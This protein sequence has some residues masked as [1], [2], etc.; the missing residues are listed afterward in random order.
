MNDNY[1]N[2]NDFSLK[3]KNFKTKN[4][5]KFNKEIL[6]TNISNTKREL[7]EKISNLKTF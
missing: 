1:V 4:I 3:S 2:S 7:Y 5:P 6:N